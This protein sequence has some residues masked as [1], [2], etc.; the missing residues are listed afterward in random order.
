LYKAVD[1]KADIISPVLDKIRSYARRAAWYDDE[2]E[3]THNP[4][5]KI[6]VNRR[7][8]HNATRDLERGA[9]GIFPPSMEGGRPG[10]LRDHADTSATGLRTGDRDSQEKDAPTLAGSEDA[11][12]ISRDLDGEEGQPRRRKTGLSGAPTEADDTASSANDGKPVF[13][14]ASQLRATI[15]NSWINFLF[16][17][18][19]VGSMFKFVFCHE[20]T[21]NRAQLL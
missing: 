19:P 21:T 11:I 6:R 7:R 3:T 14:V 4:F 18:V 12:N 10:E 2:G 8:K 20:S 17:L 9:E 5:K 15:F 1:D 13:T 16:I